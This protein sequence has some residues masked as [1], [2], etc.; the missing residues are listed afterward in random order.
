[1]VDRRFNR[2]R[3]EALHRMA[4]FLES[5]RDGRAAPEEVEAFFG[6]C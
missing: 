3:Y 5:L 2:A 4:D 1:V 6:S